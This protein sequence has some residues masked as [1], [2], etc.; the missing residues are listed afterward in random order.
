MAKRKKTDLAQ[1]LRAA[2]EKSGL[3]RF[4]L[5]RQS[6]VPYSVVHRFMEAERDVRLG[7]AS[8]MADVLGV[9]IRPLRKGA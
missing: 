9:E 8:K 5:A 1:Q 3:S 7:T 4:G 6:G 2:F